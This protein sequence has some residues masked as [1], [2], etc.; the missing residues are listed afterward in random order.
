MASGGA[1]QLRA[2]RTAAP[3]ARP[4][5]GS[6]ADELRAARDLVRQRQPQAVTAAAAPS[7]VPVI[8]SP[9]TAPPWPA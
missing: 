5:V 6:D 8:T 1:D 9:S 7:T 3:I 2:L 4:A